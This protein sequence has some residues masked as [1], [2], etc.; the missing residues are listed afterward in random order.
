MSPSEALACHVCDATGLLVIPSY[1]KLSRVTS[2]CKVWPAGGRLGV[3]Q[4]CG[5][6]QAVLDARWHQDAAAI[7]AS[8]A[9]YHQSQGAEQNVFDPVSGKPAN[10][11]DALALR[12]RTESILA[13]KGRMLDF[14]CG[15]GSLLRSFGAVFKEWRM[16]GLELRDDRKQEIES[17]GNVERLFTPPLADVPGSFDLITLIHCLEHIASPLD[18]LAQIRDKLQLGGLVLIQVPDCGANPFSLLIAD[19]ASHFCLPTLRQLAQRAG[20]EVLVA[21][22]QWVAKELTVVGRKAPGAVALTETNEGCLDAA[23]LEGFVAWLE[24]L[25]SEARTLAQ[26]KPFGLFGTSIAA[27]FL[28][29]ELGEAVDFFVDEDPNRQGKVW[30]GRPIYA[31]GQVPAGSHILVGLAPVVAVKVLER[32]KSAAIPARFYPP[33]LLP[34]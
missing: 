2:D 15:N 20:F 9:I 21:T 10:R 13:A 34:A 31:P 8:Y 33:P 29:G 7:Y 23:A 16:A 14:G 27:T 1:Q 30:C 6:A 24:R 32:L 26:R 17:I 11:S 22:N 28:S 5:C 12:L 25:A 3:C 4:Q 18:F 19:H